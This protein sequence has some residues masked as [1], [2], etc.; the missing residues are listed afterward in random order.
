[1]KAMLLDYL[2]PERHPQVTGLVMFAVMIIFGSLMYA[3]LWGRFDKPPPI[4]PVD[5]KLVVPTT[6]R[7]VKTDLHLAETGERCLECHDDMERPTKDPVGQLK[8]HKRVLHHGRNNRCFNC[9]HD[10]PKKRG[11]FVAYD[12]SPV[13]YQDVVL[14]CAKCHGPHYRDWSAGAHGRRNGYWD[15]KLGPQVAEK[16]IACHDPHWPYFKRL[17]SL[18]GPQTPGGL[19]HEEAN[20]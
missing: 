19:P 1:M 9:H 5:A 2:D 16:C 12:G 13:P 15:A 11:Q 8:E 4:Q 18:P 7:Q 6:V 10:D 3:N 14:L 20:L 17:P